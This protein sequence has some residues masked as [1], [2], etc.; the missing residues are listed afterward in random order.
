[1]ANAPPSLLKLSHVRFWENQPIGSVIAECNGTDPDSNAS[2]SYKLITTDKETDH[3][4]FSL[5]QNGTLK[6]A[7]IFNFES[8]RTNYTLLIKVTD[9]HNASLLQELTLTLQDQNDAPVF[10]SP[11]E[12]SLAVQFEIPENST[13]I[14]QLQASDEDRDTLIFEKTGG[15]EQGLF[16]LN[17][18]TGNLA[19]THAPDFENP[20]DLTKENTYQVWVQVVDPKGEYDQK[21]ISIRVKNVVEDMDKDGIED[22][23]DPDND[24]DGFN[25]AE[26]LAY[27]SDPFDPRSVANS[28]PTALTLSKSSILENQP[29]GT[30]VGKFTGTDPDNSSTLAY[31]LSKGPGDNH[32]SFFTIEADNQLISQK[33]FDYENS[34]H[35]FSVRIQVTDEHKASFSQAF[36]INLLNDPSDDT[37][38]VL[39]DNKT[40]EPVTEPKD[41]D[42]HNTTLPPNLDDNKTIAPV[43]DQNTSDDL[44]NTE[45]PLI[46]QNKT[47]NPIG[48]QPPV[49]DGNNSGV[50]DNKSQ[51]DPPVL[52]PETLKYHPIVQT[53]EVTQNEKGIYVFKGRILTNAGVKLE[54]FGIEISDSFSF[55]TYKSYIAEPYG[56]TFHIKI[57]DLAFG[58]TYYYRAFARNKIGESHGAP[59]RLKIPALPQPDAWWTSMRDA[60]N[61]WIQSPWLG[62]FQRFEHTD[63]IYHTRLGWVYTQSDVKD[64]I[65]LWMEQE[66][67]LWTQKDV[68]PYFWSDNT[69]DWLYL[70]PGKQT[71]FFNF[72]TK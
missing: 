45:P 60:G 34:E 65:W 36:I 55:Q 5:E 56:N 25:D 27:G 15:F 52:Q 7:A 50:D 13:H 43:I 47:E 53:Q 40:E 17:A 61:G 39:D 37:S 71:I 10:T 46:D 29:V 14:M 35:N 12:N 18:T 2:L 31:T 69:G 62:T 49:I 48:P 26:E 19:F 70:Y 30:L 54:E 63:W 72:S 68:W 51:T 4:L 20:K 21:H 16:D 42:D 64:G 38:P 24:N 41:N 8:N 57:T 3:A 32:N 59:K 67:W 23:Y 11:S 66:N 33:S 22:H 1:M 44:N 9:E 6:N 58:T 28:A